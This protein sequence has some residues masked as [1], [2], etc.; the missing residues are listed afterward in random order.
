MA[1]WCTCKTPAKV[2]REAEGVAICDEDLGGCGL[3]VPSDEL[4]A[5][6]DVMRELRRLHARLDRLE[7]GAPPATNGSGPHHPN[8][9]GEAPTDDGLLTGHKAI[10]D[11]LGWTSESRSKRMRMIDP[12]YPVEENGGRVMAKRARLDEW[13]RKG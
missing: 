11:Y 5:L 3:P 13:V 8:G 4:R 1:R 7:M 2:Y 12:P 6:G 9:S 10:A